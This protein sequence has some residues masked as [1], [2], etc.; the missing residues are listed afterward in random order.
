MRAAVHRRQLQ[1]PIAR[2]ADVMDIV[3]VSAEEFRFGKL[4]ATA[5]MLELSP[6]VDY[7]S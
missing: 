7:G 2:L 4:T 5:G 1:K 3:L 6:L